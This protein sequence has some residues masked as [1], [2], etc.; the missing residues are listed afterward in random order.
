MVS[1]AFN[2]G[3]GGFTTSTVDCKFNTGD[4]RGA[5]DAFLIWEIPAVLKSRRETERAQFLS[6]SA[7]SAPVVSSPGVVPIAPAPPT[8]LERL[9]SI[10]A[11][12]RPPDTSAVV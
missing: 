11:P 12:S 4:V 8:L 1:L 5:A 3:A 2:I 6:A 10:F 7:T 9:W